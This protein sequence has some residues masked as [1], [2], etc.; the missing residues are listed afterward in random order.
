MRWNDYIFLF[1]NL[2]NSIYSVVPIWNFTNSVVDLL[3]SQTQHEFTTNGKNCYIQKI[4]N[5]NSDNSISYKKY[6]YYN[7]NN[8]VEVNYEDVSYYQ[9]VLGVSNLVCP[10]GKF[11]PFDLDANINKTNNFKERANWDLK[12]FNHQKG[13]FLIF[14]LGNKNINFFYSES[15][16]SI[17]NAS[18]YFGS[19]I[20]DFILEDGSK[21]HNYEYSSSLIYAKNNYII[22]KSAGFIM[23]TGENK[24]NKADYSQ[25]NLTPVKKYS[26][27]YF[28]SD[29]NFHYFTYNDVSDFVGGY[30]TTGVNVNGNN[31]KD[32][33]TVEIK[34][35]I[36][37][38]IEFLDEVS[39]NKINFIPGT[40][41]AYY[42]IKDLNNNKI[43][44]GFMDIKQNRVLFNTDENIT[45]FVPY[46]TTEMLAITPNSA[47]KICIIKNGTSCLETCSSGNL[48]LDIGG[49]KCKTNSECDEGKIKLMPNDICINETLCDENIFVKNNSHC[50]LCKE[51]YPND[52]KYKLFNT[53]GCIDHIPNYS[54]QYNSNTYL[55]IY[56]CQKNFHPYNYTCV[57]DF[58]FENCDICYEPSNDTN[59]QKCLTCK[60][61]YYFDQN[62]CIKCNNDRCE[63]CTKGSNK[64]K[65]CTK[66]KSGYKTV[67]FTTKNPEFFYC[68]EEK[69][70]PK[71]F[72]K[73]EKNGITV[74]K[75]C[76]RKCKR[77]I[78]GGNDQQNNCLECGPGYMFR[79]GD[80]PH[81][82][83]IGYSE[84][85]YLNSYGNIKNLPNP[86]CPEDA[87]FKIKDKDSNKV[88]CIYDCKASLRNHFLFNGNCLENCPNNTT[89]DT[90][91]NICKVDKN[92]CSL[93]END[94]YIENNDTMKVV[95]TLAKTYMNE[96]KYTNKHISKYNHKNFSIILYKNESCIKAQNLRMPTIDFLNCSEVVK[97]A[98]NVTEL[99]AAIADR[100]SKK[101]PTSFIGFYHP[102]SGVKLDSDKICNNSDVQIT[103]NLYVLLDENDKDYPLQISLT[104]QGINIFDEDH[105]FFNDICFEFNNPLSRDIALQDR[106]KDIFP[107]AELCDDGCHN[108]GIDLSEMTATCNCKY[109]DVSESN[110]EPI[111]DDIFGDVFEL[112][113]SSNLEVLRCHK[114]FFKYFPKSI[115]GIILLILIIA[116]ITFSVLFFT[117]ELIKL[118]RYVLTLT[119]NYLAYLKDSEKK[120]KNP[121]KK[122]SEDTTTSMVKFMNL[123]SSKKTG[124]YQVDNTKRPNSLISSNDVAIFKSKPNKNAIIT[125]SKKKKKIKKVKKI[126][127]FLN[128]NDD[129]M[130]KKFFEEYLAPS[131]D[132]MAYDDAIVMDDRKYMEILCEILKEKQMIMNTFVASDPLKGRFI[133]IILFILNICLYLVVNGF[134]FSEEYISEL[135]NLEKEDN[136]FSFFPRSIGKLIYSTIVSMVISYITDFFFLEEKKIIGLFRREKDNRNA[137]K[138]YII[139]F[140]KDLQNRY[141]SFIVMVFVI[142]IFSFYYLVCFN[143]VYPKTQV[144]W[145]K[146][147]I[148]IM[149]IVQIISVLKCLYE[150]SMRVLSFRFKS[151]R[152][153]KASKIFD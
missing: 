21:E 76:Y 24:V 52:K 87:M 16:G 62:N 63:E 72:Y 110:L 77:C 104:Q 150:T 123:R 9:N 45:T 71:K 53:S 48:I 58:C 74:Y 69:E 136:F 105:D 151:E 137:I 128:L 117:I 122:N 115:G 54:E 6:L 121:P 135:Y 102:V 106:Q 1:I 57:P 149:I 83:C 103:E 97:K 13:Y 49:N 17:N 55:Y 143:R 61:G 2:I 116:D 64:E 98:Y 35:H 4:I 25:T 108:Q 89:L 47:Y 66:C 56:K 80:N 15:G 101:N 107:Q 86:Q 27:A 41:F 92:H 40:Q 134:F 32:I 29:Y 18:G 127:S 10:R 43:Y 141:L 132:D 65:L 133:K 109:K 124:T 70:I 99:V 114:N 111:L 39:I 60:S 73:E 113:D 126:N 91:T 38:P 7:G 31:Y 67:N 100:K 68:L 33:S 3:Y 23:N 5:K 140:I 84:N 50:G 118:K 20:Y 125:E 11:H 96:F 93:G 51:F 8:K 85:I 144:E 26:Q 120:E 90:S 46:S 19:E 152:L 37:S 146:L 130:D 129:K 119:D 145:I 42:E 112:I 30:S 148:A 138:E 142:L 82:N 75:P 153:Y 88:L 95:E 12:C 34:N 131:V 94:I 14:Y 22:L 79:P 36:L 44:H 139:T 81:N 78:I 147:S 59:N 28:T